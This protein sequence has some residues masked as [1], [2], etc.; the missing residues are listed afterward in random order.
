MD[1]YSIGVTSTVP[2]IEEQTVQDFFE[3][4]STLPEEATT[5]RQTASMW[6]RQGYLASFADT[7]IEVDYRTRE[8]NDSQTPNEESQVD[9]E[10]EA[11]SEE[12]EDQEEDE[13][14]SEETHDVEN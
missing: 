14:S 13:L 5:A 4:E 3:E 9:S 12:S 6:Q 2:A 11:A 10:R 7:L 8:T 1:N